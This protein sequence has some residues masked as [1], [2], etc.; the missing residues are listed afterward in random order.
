[1][2]YLLLCYDLA[3]HPKSIP[4]FV[5]A[6]H[7]VIHHGVEQDK[8]ISKVESFDNWNHTKTL[9]VEPRLRDYK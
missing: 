4:A 9:G 2:V 6:L 5:L 3:S 1:M 7:H 8:S